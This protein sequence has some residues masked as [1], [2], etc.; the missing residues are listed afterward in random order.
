MSFTYESKVLIH[1]FIITILALAILYSDFCSI[2]MAG[3]DLIPSSSTMPSGGGSGGGDDRDPYHW[4]KYWVKIGE[5]TFYV[6]AED[7]ELLQLLSQQLE[8]LRNAGVLLPHSINWGANLYPAEWIPQSIRRLMIRYPNGVTILSAG[9]CFAGMIAYCRYRRISGPL[10]PILQGAGSATLAHMMFFVNLCP[11]SLQRPLIVGSIG[12]SV[13]NTIC[14][15]AIAHHRSIM[16]ARRTTI[17]NPQQLILLATQRN[18]FQVLNA[19][20]DVIIQAQAIRSNDEHDSDN[21]PNTPVL[22]LLGIPI[23]YLRRTYYWLIS[24]FYRER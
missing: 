4:Q 16:Q 13:A 2:C 18:S 8:Q 11:S 22:A 21:T 7:E 24:F 15:N 3:T 20:Q 12:A 9:A 6:H 23:N 10:S 5:Q 1:S 17:I 19:D 14:R